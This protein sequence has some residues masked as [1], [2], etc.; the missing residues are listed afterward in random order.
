MENEYVSD[1]EQ[2]KTT[3]EL[4]EME[5][6]HIPQKVFR[7]MIVKMIKELRIRMDIQSEK[8]EVLMKIYKI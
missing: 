2:D 8:L 1:G 7:A 4:S 3:E 6:G 5:T